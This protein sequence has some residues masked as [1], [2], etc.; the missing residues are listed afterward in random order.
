MKVTN[1]KLGVLSVF[2]IAPQL[3]LAQQSKKQDTLQSQNVEA[4]VIIGYGRQK[5]QDVSTSLSNINAANFNQGLVTN[6]IEQISGKIPGLVV[7]RAGGDPTSSATIRIRGQVSLTGGQ[8]PLIVLNGVPLDDPKVLD[9][10]PSGDIASYTVLKDAS[11]TAIYG[12]RGANGVILVETK[13]GRNGASEIHYSG[14]IGFAKR[15]KGYDMLNA[16]QWKDAVASTGVSQGTIQG[17][18]RGGNT[19]WLDALSRT[20]LNTGHNLSISGGT[21]GFNFYGSV[22]YSDVQGV[23]INTGKQLVGINLRGEKKALNNNLDIKL[24]IINTN[25]RNRYVDPGI[26]NS[27]FGALPVYPVKNPDGSYFAFLTQGIYNPVEHQQLETKKGIQEYTIIQGSA[28]YK[29]DKI[30]KGLSVGV[31]GA[32]TRY[33]NDSIGFTPTFPVENNINFAARLAKNRISNQG[34]IHINYENSWGRNHVSAV[35]VHEYSDFEADGFGAVGQ[36]YVIEST[37]ADALQNGNSAFNQI[38]SYK[39]RFELASFLG[40]VTYDFASKYFLNASF[41]RDGSSKFGKNNRWA[42]FPA[43]SVAWAINRESF[44]QNLSWINQLKIRGGYGVTGNQDAINPYST[45]ELF[46]NVGRFYDAATNSYPIAYGPIQNANPDLKWEEVRGTDI[47]LDFGLFKNRLTGS[48]DYYIKNTKNLLFNYTVPVPP[49][50]VNTILANIGTLKNTGVDVSLQGDIIRQT[51]FKFSMYGQ[52]SFLNTKITS[53]SGKLQGF[54]LATN[55]VPAGQAVGRGMSGTTLTF[56]KEGFA[57]FVF[58]LPHYLGVDAS[59]NQL[60]SDGKGGQVTQNK[61]TPSMY[62]YIDPSPDFSY[63]FGGQASYKMIDFSFAFRGVHGQKIYDD[64]RMLM[65]N[66]TL[67]PGNNMT[68][69]GVNSPIKDQPHISDL[70]LERAGFLRLSNVSLGYNFRNLAFARN[71]RLSFTATN[72]FVITKYRG[73]DPEIAVGNTATNLGNS[74]AVQSYI[75][76]SYLTNGFYPKSRSFL[77]GLD[78]TF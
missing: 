73:L 57:P 77:F 68:M 56:M 39:N 38:N 63:G 64:S 20:A 78:V 72:V 71:I 65:D 53:L 5:A 37:G 36:Q 59:G 1:F 13:Q 23:I 22:N 67:L 58:Y 70:W 32:I 51:N 30:L 74:S 17:M 18:D 55:N 10:I 19:N 52:I 29:L 4:V 69:S 35:F 8:E 21:D 24:G 62:N 66:I 42:N 26:F 49:F 25:I 28:D 75:D 41:R 12:A 45:V 60:F 44:M 9:N 16:Q 33:H 50:L 54:D 11:A 61:L 2:A 40:R 47:G 3:F 31:L 43:F 34:N 6:P 46:G 27:A 76:S 14:T 7:T 48:V 15:T